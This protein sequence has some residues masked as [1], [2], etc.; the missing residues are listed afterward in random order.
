MNELLKENIDV[1]SRNLKS[2][3]DRLHRT[4]ISKGQ[5]RFIMTYFEVIDEFI[6]KSFDIMDKDRYHEELKNM[7]E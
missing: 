3:R 4:T 1:L 2:L 7:D 5:E 6:G